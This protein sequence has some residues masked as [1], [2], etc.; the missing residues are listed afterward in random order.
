MATGLVSELGVRFD[1][2][3]D[4]LILLGRAASGARAD[5]S[6]SVVL[7]RYWRAVFHARIHIALE[8]NSNGGELDA[9]SMRE[10]IDRIGQIEFDEVRAMLRHDDLVLPPYDD[11]EVYIE[12]AALYLELRYFAPGLLVSSFPGIAHFEALDAMFGADLDIPT[13]LEAGRPAEVAPPTVEA[14]SM[15]TVATH[16]TQLGFGMLDAAPAR[17]ATVREARASLRRSRLGRS[18]GNDVGAAIAAAHAATVEDEPMRREAEALGHEAIASLSAR[19]AA[20]LSPLD[21]TDLPRRTEPSFGPLLALV[22]DRAAAERTTRFSVE[23]RFLYALQVAALA[24]EKPQSII[25]VA[26]WIRSRGKRP[27]VRRLPATREVRIARQFAEAAKLARHTRVGAADRKLLAKLIDVT[28]ERAEDNVRDAMRPKLNATLERVSL[29]AVT[30]PERLAREKLIE[31]L[32]DTTLEHGYLSFGAVRDALSRNQLKLPDLSSAKELWDGDPLLAADRILDEELDGVYRASDVYLRAFQKLSSIPFGTRIGRIFT[33]YFALPLAAAA[34]VLEAVGHFAELA[35]LDVHVL[36]WPS[37][38]VTA[39]LFFGLIHSMFFRRAAMQFIE[40]VGM[41]LALVFV[42]LPRAMFARPTV[43][44]WFAL[45]QVRFA[46]RRGLIPAAVATVG[47]YF[48]ALRVQ[49]QWL[50][51][52]VGLAFFLAASVALDSRFGA[53]FEDFIFDQLAPGLQLVRRQWLPSFV[54]SV[55]RVFQV[56]LDLL[57][58]GIYRVDEALR[59]RQGQSRVSLYWKGF[60]GLLWGIVAYALRFYVTL[61][62]EPFIN[63]LKHFPVV[64]VADKLLLTSMPQIL[65]S[66]TQLFSPLGS[67]LGGFLAWMTMFFSPSIFGF[68]AWELNENFKLYRAT[69]PEGLVPALI[70]HDGETMR[71]LLV[72]GLHSGTLPKLYERLRRAAQRED[73]TALMRGKKLKSGNL[74]SLGKFREGL[75]EVEQAVR[76]FVDRELGALLEGAARWPYGAVDIEGI[77]LSSNRIRVRLCCRALSLEPCELRFEEQSGMVVASLAQLG[78]LAELAARSSEAAV[79]FENALAG[80]Y[81]RAEVE[82]VREQLEVELGTRAAYD[83]A[84]QALIVWPDDAYRTELVYRLGGTGTTIAPEVHGAPSTR[85]LRVLDTRHLFFREQSIGWLAWVSAWSA[86]AHADA[87]IPRL[88]RGT[89]LLPLTGPALPHVA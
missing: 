20:A 15:A 40:L 57:E 29:V 24:H 89:P 49:D 82:L 51:L 50:G 48:L 16:S 60:V 18:R 1:E 36:T 5:S 19:L 79:L 88:V 70:G 31:E 34:V 52:A 33:L 74:A 56:M 6:D 12:F 76:R 68:L 87:P 77:E 47:W 37:L 41:A 14:I 22:A 8:A 32:L 21:A 85:P 39:A 59:F 23:A 62:I 38:A 80:L 78:F 11:R 63:P 7:T 64:V 58:R 54:R 13:L 27:V 46:I 67:L 71:G 81:Q 42:R 61:M 25:D 3:P 65:A 4:P 86:A 83:I 69:R 17:P 43:R 66:A 53:L 2:L 75:H 10:R 35:H 55:G 9:A 84:D 26:G 30:D 28:R 73:D 45:P 72:P 44:R